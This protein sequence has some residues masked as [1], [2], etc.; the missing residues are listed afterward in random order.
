MLYQWI[1][2]FLKILILRL[3]M[4]WNKKM[5]VACV[6]GEIKQKQTKKNHYKIAW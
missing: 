6:T 1:V 5:V 2:N 3:Q 4:G